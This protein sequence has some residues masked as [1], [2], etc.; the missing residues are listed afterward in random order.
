VRE[1]GTGDLWLLERSAAGFAPRHFLGEGFGA[2][3]LVG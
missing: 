2:Y 1:K 3:N